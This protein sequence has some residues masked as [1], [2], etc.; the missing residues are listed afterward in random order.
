MRPR[1]RRPGRNRCRHGAILLGIFGL[2]A[3][4][5]AS[6]A[7]TVGIRTSVGL[8]VEGGAPGSIQIR[9][10]VGGG[11]VRVLL[12]IG[13]SAEFGKDF[14]IRGADRVDA[15][16]ATVTL[17][18]WEGSADLRIEA[19]DDVPAE[20]DEGI[21]LTLREAEGHRVDAAAGNATVTIPR[22][23]FAVTTTRDGG[24]GSLRQALQNALDLEG[25]DTVTFDTTVGPFAGKQTILLTA[26]LPELSGDLAID[27]G[28]EGSLWK[29]TGVTVSGGGRRRVFSVAPGA[30]VTLRSLTVSDG[31]AKR[32]GGIANAGTL[33]VRGVTFLRN[34]ARSEGGALASTGG[35]LTVINST[36]TENSARRAGGG[37]A[38]RGGTVTVTNCTFSNNLARSGGGLFSDGIL[39]VRNTILA[40]S[41]GASDCVSRGAFDP[42]STHNVIEANDGCG[43]P[44]STEDP[45][46]APLGDFNGPVP[47]MPLGG[48]SLAINLGDNAAALDEDGTR[49]HW[50]QR[51]NG[52]PRVVAGFSDIG[53]FETQAFPMLQVDTFEDR[54]WRACTAAG[55]GD[56]SLRG[57]VML[58]NVSDRSRVITFDPR[59]FAEPRVIVLDRPLPG[60]AEDLSLDAGGTAGVTL[61]AAGPFPVFQVTPGAGVK[62][63]KV[64][65]EGAA[66]PSI[67]SSR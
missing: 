32:G 21:T 27:G 62:F 59:L 44:I 9:R 55:V 2:S 46:L 48:G 24:E 47:T 61:R 7:A 31:K 19:V 20:A 33:I 22:N 37:L 11:E 38:A 29:A 39:L 50:D 25:A 64:V 26:D 5:A 30:R 65:W 18:E 23:D 15:A 34:V 3:A 36:F 42:A 13:G 52:D 35:G 6:Q 14:V 16:S 63:L 57:A 56:C 40:N 60:L 45:R 41:G 49:L 28:I 67:E 51:G 58:A 4:G 53:A 43:E 54:E 12:A 1:L 17:R 8:A 66:G 10:D